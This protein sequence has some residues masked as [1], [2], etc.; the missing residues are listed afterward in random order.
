VSAIIR[1]EQEATPRGRA[2]VVGCKKAAEENPQAQV[3]EDA[4]KD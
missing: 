1:R 2:D 4:E 3:Q